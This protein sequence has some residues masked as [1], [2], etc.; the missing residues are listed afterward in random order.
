MYARARRLADNQ[1]AGACGSLYY[2]AGTKREM[3]FAETTGAYLGQQGVEV[4]LA[5]IARGGDSY[6]SYGGYGKEALH[7]RQT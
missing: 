1:D 5:L 7:A 3:R 2:R 6:G 4:G